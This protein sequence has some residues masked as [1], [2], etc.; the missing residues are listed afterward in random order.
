MEIENALFKSSHFPQSSFSHEDEAVDFFL[1][2][3]SDLVHSAHDVMMTNAQ[4]N[5]IYNHTHPKTEIQQSHRFPYS[6]QFLHQ[7]R[8]RTFSSSGSISTANAFSSSFSQFHPSTSVALSPLHQVGA[9]APTTP[10]VVRAA[11]AIFSELDYEFLSAMGQVL[12][13]AS[14]QM[15]TSF[16]SN[17]NPIN[18]QNQAPSEPDSIAHVAPASP[19]CSSD[20]YSS[21]FTDELLGDSDELLGAVD[22]MEEDAK[23]ALSRVLFD[24]DEESAEGEVITSH[25]Q[26]L[27]DKASAP[28]PAGIVQSDPR[29]GTTSAAPSHNIPGHPHSTH[30]GEGAKKAAKKP[31]AGKLGKGGR[32]I[33]KCSKGGKAESVAKN[34]PSVGKAEALASK[35]KWSR[36]H[37]RKEPA[38][39][40]FETTEEYEEAWTRWR[41]LRDHNNDAVKRSRLNK[42]KLLPVLCRQPRCMQMNTCLDAMERKMNLLIKAIRSPQSLTHEERTEYDSIVASENVH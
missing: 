13:P 3:E 40:E 39:G 35:R 4:T 25:P 20:T 10:S 38:R 32:A 30:V 9:F 17:M 5:G 2:S 36:S 11:S 41:E 26:T 27:G 15:Q 21:S 19:C 22:T 1:Q 23:F 18:Q 33:A 42:K 37:T 8:P 31:M 6:R 14:P 7:S 28:A 16:Y 29:L 12:P 24:Q 34:V